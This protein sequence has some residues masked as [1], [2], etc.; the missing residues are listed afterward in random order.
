MGARRILFLTQWFDPE[1]AAL[2]GL[3]FVKALKDQGFEIEV[4]TGFPN[5]PTGRI[6]SG[7]KLR[8]YTLHLMEGIKV[9]RLYLYPSHDTSSLG[10]ALNFLSF[11]ISALIFCL[12]HGGRYDA[13]YVYHPP[14]TVGLAAT[15]AGYI[16]HTPFVLDIQDLWPDS[17]AA[18]GMSGTGW[19][20]KMLAP[21]CSLVYR[22]AA[23]IV[24][25]SA[26]MKTRLVERGV[27][28]S[29]MTTIYNWAD[30]NSAAPSGTLDLAGYSFKDRFNFVFAGNLGR[31]Q[32]LETL[33][34]A[35]QIAETKM[36]NIHLTLIGDGV[37]RDKL[38]R[39]LKMLDNKSVSIRP[40]V[41]RSSIGDVLDAAD[42][43]LIHLDSDPLFEIT[44]PGKTQFYLA[45][46][47]P[48]LIGVRGEA[49]QIVTDAGA[50][51]SVAPRDAEAMAAAMLQMAKMPPD[52]LALM[53]RCGRKAYERRFSFATGIEATKKVLSSVATTK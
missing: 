41:P 26:G 53:G 6:A 17:V 52:I 43:L 14:I 25:Q 8:P 16:T 39:L 28:S 20:A 10:R 11:F 5:Y 3:A 31:F 4:A 24:P 13:I 22:R 34:H 30:E 12:V 51:I 1:P 7:Y 19:L 40:S 42:V 37:E 48:I 50:G 9:H 32:G 45:M 2:K 38:A 36:P 44:I 49:A 46:G 15:L 23:A 33:V 29:K 21:M 27:P 47:K 18:S 35:A